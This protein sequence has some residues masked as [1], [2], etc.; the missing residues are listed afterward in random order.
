[1]INENEKIELEYEAGLVKQYQT[2]YIAPLD[3]NS[4]TVEINYQDSGFHTVSY[5]G[6]LGSLVCDLMNGPFD[7]SGE[8]VN[9]LI[10][11][12]NSRKTLGDRG[13]VLA[14]ASAQPN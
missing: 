11:F 9:C 7:L 14:W 2:C 6:G 10:T 13:V 4:N 1:M 12:N 8:E 3:I 5:N